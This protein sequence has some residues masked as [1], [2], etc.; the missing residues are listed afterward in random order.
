MI[1]TVRLRASFCALRLAYSE[2]TILNTVVEVT[3]P[4]SNTFFVSMLISWYFAS[5]FTFAKVDVESRKIAMS[6]L[7]SFKE[8]VSLCV[9]LEGTPDGVSLSCR[10]FRRIWPVRFSIGSICM[11]ES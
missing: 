3:V 9:G 2:L 7:V 11:R 1:R 6:D 10:K 8:I 5:I 4:L